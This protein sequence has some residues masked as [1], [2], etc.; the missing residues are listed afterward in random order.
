MIWP[1]K[2]EDKLLVLV[3][4]IMKENDIKKLIDEINTITKYCNE[5]SVMKWNEFQACMYC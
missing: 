2:K 4:S 3:D 1:V 5:K